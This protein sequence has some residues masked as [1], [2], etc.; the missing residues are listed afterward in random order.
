VEE[1]LQ[2]EDLK[3]RVSHYPLAVQ[4]RTATCEQPRPVENV[5]ETLEPEE[6]AVSRADVLIETQLP[7][8]PEHTPKLP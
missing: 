7:G 1:P 3:A 2:L 4:R 6:D 5:N 8:R